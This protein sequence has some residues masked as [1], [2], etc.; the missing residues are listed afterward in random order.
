MRY[1]QY[2]TI[3]IIIGLIESCYSP[4]N[5]EYLQQLSRLE[6]PSFLIDHYPEN[7]GVM[8]NSFQLSF[9]EEP[10]IGSDFCTYGHCF[11]KITVTQNFMDQLLDSLNRNNISIYQPNQKPLFIPLRLMKKR[12]K[13][14]RFIHENTKNTSLP[15]IQLRISYFRCPGL[16]DILILMKNL[17]QLW[18]YLNHFRYSY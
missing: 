15:T 5:H 13:H 9:K 11:L 3:C 6:I 2:I 4:V 1:I 14:D 7:L 16:M 17:K 10:E 18:D 12:G 8:T